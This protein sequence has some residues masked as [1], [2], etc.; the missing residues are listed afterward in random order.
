MKNSWSLMVITCYKN[1]LFLEHE[2]SEIDHELIRNY[3]HVINY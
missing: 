3:N 2:L 1:E